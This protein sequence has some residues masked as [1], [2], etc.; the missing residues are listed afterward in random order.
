MKLNEMNLNE[1][2]ENF[3]LLIRYDESV[4]RMRVKEIRE[5]L[6]ITKKE[7]DEIVDKF[8]GTELFVFDFDDDG[9]V[10]RVGGTASVILLASEIEAGRVGKEHE[11]PDY[12]ARFDKN[13]RSHPVFGR[14]TGAKGLIA[15]IVGIVGLVSG[16]LGIIAFVWGC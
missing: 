8:R 14:V 4:G 13:I 15:V 2:Q 5:Q 12:A 11:K 6:K 9:E 16:L 10:T 3:V 1:L 7:F